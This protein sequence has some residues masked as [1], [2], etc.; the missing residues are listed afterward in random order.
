MNRRTRAWTQATASAVI[1]LAAIM[2]T[3]LFA[4]SALGASLEAVRSG[5]APPL[6]FSSDVPKIQRSL[7]LSDL[8]F[9]KRLPL[10]TV[11]TDFNKLMDL[12]GPVRN[13]TLL[14]WL[15]ERVR[16]VI[17][18]DFKLTVENSELIERNHSF[19]NQD[20]GPAKAFFNR[21]QVAETTMISRMSNFGVAMYMIWK[22][23][24]NLWK[25]HIEGFSEDLVVDTPRIGIV[26]IGPGM[27]RPEDRAKALSFTERVL[28]LKTLFHE[29]RHSDG[30]GATLAFQHDFCPRNHPYEGEPACDYNLNGPYAVSAAVLKSVAG[31]CFQCT[32]AE[33]EELL[34]AAADSQSR[35]IEQVVTLTESDRK[36]L[37][38]LEAAKA[39][40]S[41]LAAFRK[42]ARA[43]GQVQR[44]GYVDSRPEGA[45]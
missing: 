1:A 44:F 37:D 15:H 26:E 41:E 45:R 33:K 32:R 3:G 30:N 17:T 11:G 22:K 34:L 8:E 24:R 5:K 21:A 25:F 36:A 14:D 6:E 7:L 23:Q 42:E 13:D 10:K 12:K 40:E 35:V 2:G 27:F 29:A 4:S 38:A 19:Q 31:G 16:H 28:R 18:P 20:I 39:S 9:F 43:R